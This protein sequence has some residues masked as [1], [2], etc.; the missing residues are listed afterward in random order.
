MRETDGRDR[1][2]S[3]V[4]SDPLDLAKREQEKERHQWQH[5]YAVGHCIDVINRTSSCPC[6]CR[7]T[8]RAGSKRN[9]IIRYEYVAG[10]DHQHKKKIEGP[11]LGELKLEPVDK[12][13]AG[14]SPTATQL[15]DRQQN[16]HQDRPAILANSFA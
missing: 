13:E 7:T 2:T 6:R 16:C 3:S 8:S 14:R 10:R 5:D 9:V 15:L 4:G 12:Q 11:R 1:P